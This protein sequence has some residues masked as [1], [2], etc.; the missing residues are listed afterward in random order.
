MALHRIT[1][2]GRICIGLD[3]E[4]GRVERAPNPFGARL[5]PLSPEKNGHHPPG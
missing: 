1:Q 3:D 5:L 2:C 4:T